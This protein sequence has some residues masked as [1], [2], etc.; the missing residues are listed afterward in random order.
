[1]TSQLQLDARAV[2]GRHAKTFRFAARWLPSDVH[3]D[4]AVVYAFCR[5]L[6]DV[7]DETP[8]RDEADRLLR[9]VR[10]Q[11]ETGVSTDPLTLAYFE[12]ATRRNLPPQAVLGLIDGMRQDLH[13]V[14]LAD[15]RELVRYGWHVA[16]TVGILLCGLLGVRDPAGRAFAID[17]GVAMQLSNIARDVAEDARRGRVYLP[18]TRLQAAGTTPEAVLAGT[19]PL[20]AVAHGV[21]GVLTLADRYY[22]SAFTGLRYIPWRGRVAIAAA[23]WLYRRIGARLRERA[24]HALFG[25]VYVS[26]WRKVLGLV[27]AV[28]L[29]IKASFS[30]RPHDADL[31]VA[32]TGLYGIDAR[33]SADES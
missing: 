24:G 6:D 13:P 2:L 3:D 20:E 30:S 4:V 26:T 1:M 33:A 31:H 9:A 7:A 17:L 10:S 27:P 11:V 12:V 16:G 22:A 15:D 32:L 29:S 25:R 21:L 18:R 28:G 5:W 23:G 19:A 8:D 14:R